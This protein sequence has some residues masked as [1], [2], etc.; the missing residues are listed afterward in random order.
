MSPTTVFVMSTNYAGST[1]LGLCLGAHPDVSFAGE[2]A[3]VL[4]RRKDG[5]WRHAKFCASCK[6]EACPIWTPQ[7]IAEMRRGSSLDCS[8]IATAAFPEARFVVDGSKD[9]DWL[10]ATHDVGSRV[11]HISKPVEAYVGSVR[12]RAKS[13]RPAL[14]IAADWARRNRRIRAQAARLGLPY[15]HLRYEDV[16]SDLEASVHRLANFL[17]VE[18][19]ASQLRP[20]EHA[21]HHLKGNPGVAA[22]IQRN[23][24]AKVRPD[25]GWRGRVSDREIARMHSLPEVE[26][27]T[28]ALGHATHPAGIVRRVQ[29][30]CIETAV[31]SA[32]RV[33]AWARR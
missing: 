33:R 22:Q 15:L 30:Y 21:G 29:G 6:E 32:R 24:A 18:P 11:I 26:A 1:L 3:L 19:H 20:F 16:A 13:P 10:E 12:K 2:P 27:E 25:V 17:A 4:R 8:R 28:R 5:S 14:F 9:L 23:G 7:R 31:T